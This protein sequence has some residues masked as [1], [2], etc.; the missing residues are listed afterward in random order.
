MLSLKEVKTHGTFFCENI[1]LIK[2][3]PVSLKLFIKKSFYVRDIT[4]ILKFSI[5]KAT[6]FHFIFTTPNL[7]FTF[8]HLPKVNNYLK[9]Q[10]VGSDDV[11]C[12]TII[13]Q[14]DTLFILTFAVYIIN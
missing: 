9:R 4:F 5:Y 12:C 11:D 8:L 3:I 6:D 7:Y 1:K 2:K 14:L 10:W 13:H